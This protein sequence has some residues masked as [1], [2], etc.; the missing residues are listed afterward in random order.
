MIN[1]HGQERLEEI[2]HRMDVTM[3]CS[4][5]YEHLVRLINSFAATPLPD[6]TKTLEWYTQVI[7]EEM[8]LEERK[9]AF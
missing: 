8:S 2:A 6:V 1:K 3:G 7:R 9:Q 5:S 4:G